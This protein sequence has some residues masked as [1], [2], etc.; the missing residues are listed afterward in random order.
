MVGERV[1]MGG[2]LDAMLTHAERGK[3]NG[4]DGF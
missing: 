3:A 4:S 2:Q 1:N